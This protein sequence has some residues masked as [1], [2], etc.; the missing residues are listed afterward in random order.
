[1]GTSLFDSEAPMCFK[2]VVWKF[3]ISLLCV[4][5]FLANGQTVLSSEE[6]HVYALVENSRG[7]R[8]MSK[9]ERL[10][11]A[12]HFMQQMAIEA[13]EKAITE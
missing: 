2:N 3:H 8:S 4:L 11:Q 5:S 12:S 6:D 13:S 7:L 10:D 1:M 9:R